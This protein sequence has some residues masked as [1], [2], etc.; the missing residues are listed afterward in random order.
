[1]NDKNNAVRKVLGVRHKA[2]QAQVRLNKDLDEA[3]PKVS[4]FLSQKQITFKNLLFLFSQQQAI[5][6]Q[7][8]L[9]L[10]LQSQMTGQL[11]NQISRF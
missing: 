4:S 5:G 3:F 1:M 11:Q 7:A 9:S 8:N 10:N 2:N 6:E